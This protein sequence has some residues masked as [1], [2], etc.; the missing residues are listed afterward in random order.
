MRPPKRIAHPSRRPP[1]GTKLVVGQSPSRVGAILQILALEAGERALGNDLAVDR[2]VEQA[3]Q[4]LPH[5]ARRAGLALLDQCVEQ[6]M[7]VAAADVG[8]RPAAPLGQH[9]HLEGALDLLPALDVGLGVLLDETVRHGLD[10]AGKPDDERIVP[11]LAGIRPVDGF[12]E[13]LDRRFPRLLDPHDRI[14]AERDPTLRAPERP[15]GLR[16]EPALAAHLVKDRPAHHAARSDAQHQSRDD[17]VA[18]LDAAFSRRLQ[19]L[20]RRFREVLF[21]ALFPASP[22]TACIRRARGLAAP[23]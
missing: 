8:D 10:R 2:P 17:R 7:H 15:A 11:R 13:D 4:M 16:A 5:I 22:P 9:M 14:R 1:H 20:Q 21:H 12:V 3:R 19:P 18:E 23:G 6:R